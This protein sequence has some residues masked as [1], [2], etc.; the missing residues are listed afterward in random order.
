MTST[1][2]DS[3]ATYFHS[4]FLGLNL[5]ENAAQ[6]IKQFYQKIKAF[7][8]SADLSEE[9]KTDLLNGL[10]TYLKVD[11]GNTVQV[12]RFA[13]NYMQEELADDYR[14]HMRRERFP[15]TAIPKDISE[16][17]GSLR[18][19]KFRFPRQ[20]TLSGPPDAVRDLV[21]VKAVEGAGGAQWT[22]VTIRGQ[23]ESQD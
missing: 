22:E 12:G 21:T 16:I 11:Q 19:R 1:Q 10:Y 23:I 2:R 15:A 17:Q 7:I 18:Q 20:I 5:P 8:R 9:Y 4:T 14:A 13:D 6:Q 3:A